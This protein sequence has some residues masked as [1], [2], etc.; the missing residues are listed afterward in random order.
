MVRER[1]TRRRDGLDP[2]VAELNHLAITERVVLEVDPSAVGK[3]RGRTRPRDQLGESGDVVG[4]DVSVEDGGDRRAL[5]LGECDVV[6]D[7]VDVGVDDGEG[8]V[9]L[10]AQEVGGAGGL[11][12]EELAEVHGASGSCERRL[13]KLSSDLL[14]SNGN[15]LRS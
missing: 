6:V 14:N 1:V 15:G 12:V 10:A 11:V 5:A 2:G 9:R 7:Q 8:A 13:D 4:L 3:K